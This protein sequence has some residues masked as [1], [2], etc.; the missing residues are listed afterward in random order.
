L[1]AGMPSGEAFDD[2]LFAAAAHDRVRGYLLRDDATVYA[3]GY[4]RAY[5]NDA[6]WFEKTGYAVEHAASFPGAALLHAMVES[7]CAEARFTLLDFGF[8]DAQYKKEAATDVLNVA[9]VW[10]LRPGF[11]RS[12]L[13]ASHRAFSVVADGAAAAAARLGLKD[14]LRRAVRKSA[15]R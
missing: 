8:G 5:E 13:A 2:A 7:L 10:W 15:S 1:D 9:R 6:L 14:R 12:A 3:Y 11:G 4:C